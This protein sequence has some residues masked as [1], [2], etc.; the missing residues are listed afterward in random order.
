MATIDWQ[1]PPFPGRVLGRFGRHG[2][3]NVVHDP[4]KVGIHK[5][6][7]SVNSVKGIE[8]YSGFYWSRYE[9][10]IK[11]DNPADSGPWKVGLLFVIA[12]VLYKTKIIDPG[13]AKGIL[14]ARAVITRMRDGAIIYKKKLRDSASV[15]RFNA[16][17][18]GKKFLND[19]DFDFISLDSEEHRLDLETY[20][21]VHVNPRPT[22]RTEAKLL[23]Q[24]PPIGVEIS[25]FL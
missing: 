2:S 25:L 7:V 22:R 13:S 5:G 4:A 17:V 14:A 8:R 9:F 21:S 19:E 20:A 23:L 3:F 10:Q 24:S 15:G 6:E 18:W 1:T 11:P 16:F 12:G